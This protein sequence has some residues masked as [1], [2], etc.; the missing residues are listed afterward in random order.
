[1][2]RVTRLAR[3]AILLVALVPLAACELDSLLDVNV[4]GRVPD[5]ALADPALAVT[6]VNSVIADLECAWNNYAAAAALMSDEFMQASGNLNQRNWGSR[7]IL[8]DDAAMATGTCRAPYGIYTTLHT[9]RFQ[10]QVSAKDAGDDE[11]MFYDHDFIR[12]LEYGM[13]PAGGC[14][15][16]IDRL[17]ML[18]TDS[19]SIRDIILFP[20]LRRE[21]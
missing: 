18:L 17:M 14:G 3:R 5:D 9:A 15:I 21:G 2:S 1:M 13:P 6:M 19:A 7:R 16:G 20:A 12:A 4:P 11:A 10:A 8:A